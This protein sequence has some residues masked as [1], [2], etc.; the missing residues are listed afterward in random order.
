MA[1]VTEKVILP[2][3]DKEKYFKDGEIVYGKREEVEKAADKVCADGFKNIVLLGIGGTE[4]ELAP[5]EY[6]VKKYSDI[7]ISAYNAA[8]ANTVHPKNITKDTVVVTASASGDT[9]EIVEATEWIVE[10]GAQ[11]IAFTKK[12]GK[13]GKF[14]TEKGKIVIEADVTTGGCEFSYVLF[15]FLAFKIMNNKGAFPKYKE[16]A[17]GMKGVFQ[18][19][20]D[21]RVQFDARAEE[22][23]KKYYNAPYSIFCGSGAAWGETLLFAMCILEEMQWVRTRPV[24]SAQFFHG[25]LELVEKGVPVFVVKGEDEYRAQD[26]RVENFLKKIGHEDAVVIDLAEFALDGVDKEFR[27]IYSPMITTA[28]LTDRMASYYETYTKHNLNY[29]RYYRQ[30]EY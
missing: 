28:L 25:T 29:R 19:L 11:V 5:I 10:T 7:D 27:P 8:D 4:F 1:E 9:V 21:I 26:T 24:T 17:D 22:A 15:N 20:Y 14:L 3:I 16:F 18:N 2:K 23:A 6:Q 12:E 30:F 13:L